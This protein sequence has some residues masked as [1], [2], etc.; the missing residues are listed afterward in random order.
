MNLVACDSCGAVFDANIIEFPDDTIDE[1]NV[2][3]A[4]FTWNAES[5]KYVPYI[6]CPVCED[7]EI[8]ST[9]YLE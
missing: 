2:N 5:W 8:L 4:N 3:L 1:C 6:I 9:N 7:G